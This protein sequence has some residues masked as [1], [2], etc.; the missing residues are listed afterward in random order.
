[1]LEVIILET[2]LLSANGKRLKVYPE[3]SK[4]KSIEDWSKW[5]RNFVEAY[6]EIR[7][8]VPQ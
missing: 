5:L 1:M 2:Q 7:H 8:S 6:L 3:T 4:L